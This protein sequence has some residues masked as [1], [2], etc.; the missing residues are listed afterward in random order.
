MVPFIIEEIVDAVI[1]QMEDA[2]Y[3]GYARVY[4]GNQLLLIDRNDFEDLKKYACEKIGADFDD[5][6]KT[7]Q[8]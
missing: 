3:C 7:K 6:V 4:I 1:S 2:N 5:I 8:D